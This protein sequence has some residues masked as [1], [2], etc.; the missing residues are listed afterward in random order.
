MDEHPGRAELFFDYLLTSEINCARFCL[1]F[2]KYGTRSGEVI[3]QNKITGEIFKGKFVI[4]YEHHSNR[5]IIVILITGAVFETAHKCKL[6]P[7]SMFI[8]DTENFY[9]ELNGIKAILKS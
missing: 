3:F 2:I 6:M 9:G 5:I 8:A 7:G 4:N 1:R